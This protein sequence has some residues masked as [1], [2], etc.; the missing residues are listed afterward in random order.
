MAGRPFMG[1]V[2]LVPLVFVAFRVGLLMGKQSSIASGPTWWSIV[3]VSRFSK[4]FQLHRAPQSPHL[5]A[6][7][8]PGAGA[9][10]PD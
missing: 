4:P 7:L 3:Y 6:H 9:L 1:V 10:E 5:S 8:S 2:T